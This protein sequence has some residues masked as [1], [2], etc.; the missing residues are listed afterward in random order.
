MRTILLAGLLCFSSFLFA[1][2]TLPNTKG[3][4]PLSS[5]SGN[6]NFNLPNQT[7]AVIVGIS[8]YADAMI[9]DLH[10]AHQD[11]LAF[12]EYL[13][14][15]AGGSEKALDYLELAM[16]EEWK[17]SVAVVVD[18]SLLNPDFEQIRH[19][20]RFKNLKNHKTYFDD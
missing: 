14:G 4:A 7:K 8:D 18:A 10:F 20:Q 13:R 2:N 12:A 1:Q 6:L 15:P 11:A 5:S 9:R 17:P 19:D 16:E 3:A